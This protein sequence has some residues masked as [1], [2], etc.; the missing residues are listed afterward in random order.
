M[1]F[2]SFNIGLKSKNYIQKRGLAIS[3]LDG[4]LG[5]EGPALLTATTRNSYSFPSVKPPQG[6][7]VR[8]PSISAPLK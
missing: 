8:L 1:S 7:R 5:S 2:F 4:S 3:A 6:P